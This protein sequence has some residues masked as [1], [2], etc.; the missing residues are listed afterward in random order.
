MELSL[1]PLC[2]LYQKVCLSG[3]C[4]L[5][6]TLS[7][8]SADGWGFFPHPV[9]CLAWD[10]PALAPAGYWVGQS[11]GGNMQLPGGLTPIGTPWNPAASVFFATVSH[12]HPPPSQKS[13]QCYQVGWPS[14][15]TGSL[16]FSPL[17]PG[18]HE[19]LEAPSNSGVS[20]SPGLWNSYD[21]T[22]MIFKAR[23][24]GV[25]SSYYQIP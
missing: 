3:L 22:L 10:I 24:S 21:Q 8:L 14:S 4:V 13:L 12:S 18:L 20:D 1:V 25:S 11:P 15:F 9:G 23:F 6:K 2:R 16:F 5:R 7:S 19:N 17:S